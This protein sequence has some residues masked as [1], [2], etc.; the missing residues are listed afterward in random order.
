MRRSFAQMHEQTQSHGVSWRLGAYLVAVK[1][2]ADA[3]AVR[4]IYP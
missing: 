1:R 2:V 3:T 4:G